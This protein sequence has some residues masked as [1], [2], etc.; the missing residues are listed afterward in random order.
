M[1]KHGP[2]A[3]VFFVNLHGARHA[4]AGRSH[5]MTGVPSGVLGGYGFN[6]DRSRRDWNAKLKNTAAGWVGR[7][8][9][10]TAVALDD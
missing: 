7:H 4:A 10:P 9:Q 3:N 6:R 1:A 5:A 8:P 2:T